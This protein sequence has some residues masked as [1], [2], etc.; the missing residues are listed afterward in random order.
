M[1][2]Q[3]SVWQSTCG[4][5]RSRELRFGTGAKEDGAYT[6]LDVRVKQVLL[7]EFHAELTLE[8]Q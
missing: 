7:A 5:G 8:Q 1:M 2:H 3:N 4:L 6:S